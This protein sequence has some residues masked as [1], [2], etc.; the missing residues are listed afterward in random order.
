MDTQLNH[1]GGRN[2]QTTKHFSEQRSGQ[3]GITQD[4]AELVLRYGK[5]HQDKF[6]LN[7]RQAEKL[8]NEFKRVVTHGH[9]VKKHHP[10]KMNVI[11][12]EVL[13]QTQKEIKIL[14]NIASK[15]GIVI[16]AVAGTVITAYRYE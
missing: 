7:K 9:A 12:C 1:M 6:S 2:M 4:M 14:Q 15:G 10:E 8:I 16:I 5:K 3:R 13:T 11:Q